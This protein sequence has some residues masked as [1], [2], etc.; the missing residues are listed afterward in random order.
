MFEYKCFIC[1][2]TEVK[3]WRP[4]HTTEPLI[5]ANCAEEHQAKHTYT[6]ME[7]WEKIY[8]SNDEFHW[9]GVPFRVEDRTGEMVY[10]EIPMEKWTINKE[11]RI[12]S[13]LGCIGPEGDWGPMTDQLSLD[14]RGVHS[15]CKSG[16]TT[17]LPAI[18]DEKGDMWGY[19]SV[20][21]HL[22]IWWDGLPL[23]K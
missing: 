6:P 15:F 16:T 7:R 18:P 20:P 1:G 17:M 10:V 21:E 4:A 11:G 22:C 9:V 3:L 2:A 14:L 23:R 8:H 12:P 5:C 19:T 13:Y